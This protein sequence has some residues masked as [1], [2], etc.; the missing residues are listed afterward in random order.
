MLLQLIIVIPARELLIVVIVL[1]GVEK[2]DH[3]GVGPGL[4]D[5]KDLHTYE[6]EADERQ[7]G[8]VIEIVRY[9]ARIDLNNVQCHTDKPGDRYKPV[10][11]F[12]SLLDVR[13]IE[14]LLGAFF[15]RAHI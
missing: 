5:R 9:V 14:E 1:Q 11:Y 2:C 15:P 6:G 10:Y 8:L 12:L 3:E 7:I 13:V 4:T